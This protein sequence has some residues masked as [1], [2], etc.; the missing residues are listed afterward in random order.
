MYL[1]SPH[2]RLGPV[3]P[4]LVRKNLTPGAPAHQVLGEDEGEG[5][6]RVARAEDTE[7]AGP[8]MELDDTRVRV[9]TV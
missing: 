5:V 6:W 2:L 4:G 1:R 8:I 3:W 7:V 9:V